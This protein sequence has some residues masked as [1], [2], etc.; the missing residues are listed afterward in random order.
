ML[1]LPH[2]CGLSSLYTQTVL[3]PAEELGLQLGL[4]G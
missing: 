4:G 3:G 1:L 2:M